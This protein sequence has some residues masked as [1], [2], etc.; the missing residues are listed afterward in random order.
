MDPIVA[1]AG[2]A[3]T[4]VP[5]SH[6]PAGHPAVVVGRIG[7]LLVN[8]GSPSGTDYWS[9]RR[10]LKEFLADRRVIEVW[11]PLWWTILN[12][13]VLTTRPSKSGHAYSIVWDK[14]RNEG[15]LVRIT[16][17]Q[18]EKL[19]AALAKVDGRITVDWAMRYGAP[20]VASR[21]EALKQAGCDRILVAPLYP[22]YAAAT[23]ATVN[24]VAFAALQ[25]MR[26]QPAL[27][28]LPP[29]HDEPAYIEAL[30]TTMT[31]SIAKLDFEPEL[32]LASFH[33]LPREYLDKGDPYHCQ[34]HKTVRLLRDRLGWPKEKLR[35]VFQSRF[36]RAEW[37]Q[38]YTDVTIAELAK[39]GVK[40]I[41]VIMPGFS[42][43]C[44][45]TLE[46]I[47]IRGGETFHE[48]GGEQY[49][50]I[51]CLN[52]GPEGMA[53]LEGLVKRELSGWI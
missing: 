16:R 37:L 35:I 29:Y 21:I 39:S 4:Q 11:R 30:A 46:E 7:V 25:K 45:E 31:A 40:R 28:T 20:S 15:P 36:G 43:D 5:N 52:D 6:T 1:R 24:D 22:Q 51:P 42:A 47:A 8:L 12:L 18:A 48:N 10:Y 34:C 13:F 26:W 38:P 49:A 50:A 27:R 32:V 53:L 17:S 19:G 44:L 23:T 41:A 33:G 3:E 2:Q 9:M 14:E